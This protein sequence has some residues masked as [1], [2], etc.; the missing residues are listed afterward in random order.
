MKRFFVLLLILA[1]LTQPVQAQN[2]I[3]PALPEDRGALVMERTTGQVLYSQKAQEKMYPASLTK[4]LTALVVL[5]HNQEEDRLI[6]GTEMDA[7]P[8]S[9]SKAFL[10]KGKSI[11]IKD[12]LAGLL[13]PSGG[14][15]AVALAVHT[16]RVEQ[17]DVQLPI[18]QALARFS[19]LM[20]AKAETLGMKNSH[21]SNPH[22]LHAEDHYT[23]AEDLATLT[24]AVLENP[25]LESLV[26]EAFY[27]TEGGQYTFASTNVYLHS[28]LDDI[29]FLYRKGINPNYR[30]D[31]T[32][33]KTGFT[34]EAGRCLIFTT[35]KGDKSLLGILLRSD[36][37]SVYE[38]GIRIMDAVEKDL[39]WFETPMDWTKNQKLTLDGPFFLPGKS[40]DLLMPQ[41]EKE[42][43]P[44]AWEGNLE[45]SLKI[46]SEKLVVLEDENTFKLLEP[47]EEGEVVGVLERVYQG[48]ILASQPVKVEDEIAPFDLWLLPLGTLAVIGLVLLA[49]LGQRIRRIRRIR[50]NRI[51]MK[52]VKKW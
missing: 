3:D 39:T 17:K 23:T 25:L 14:D 9:S 44:S 5:D 47:L 26:G 42:L 45:Y 27:T 46:T 20:N 38:E 16:A 33:V 40:Q 37:S 18:N 2:W 7:I 19:Q 31:V 15:A 35:Q 1:T 52:K 32:G 30:E 50:R 28:R 34:Q 49:F 10:I 29:W 43:Y 13:L 48:Q 4:L 12:A 24:L 36:M 11:T 6:P 21:F 41:L 22:G 8:S 51:R